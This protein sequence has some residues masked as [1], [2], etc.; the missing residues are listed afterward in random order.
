MSHN[1]TDNMNNNLL[2]QYTESKRIIRQAMDDN[3]LVLFNDAY[4]GWKYDNS[5]LDFEFYYELV[6][7][8]VKK[9]DA[10]IEK[11]IIEYY[12]ENDANV[13]DVLNC[14]MIYPI[15][16]EKAFLYQLLDLYT[17]DLVVEKAACY[18]LLV[19]NNIPGCKWLMNYE[20]YDYSSFDVKWIMLCTTNLL[21]SI[22]KNKN[23]KESI[24]RAIEVEYKTGSISK[25]LVDIYFRFFI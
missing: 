6:S 22:S 9:P 5:T 15:Q 18:D 16:N 1:I 10:D 14:V 24:K 11:Q 21:E 12:N 25:E 17:K 8:G 7:K 4:S 19:K 3:Q 23:A 13:S 2:D 20:E